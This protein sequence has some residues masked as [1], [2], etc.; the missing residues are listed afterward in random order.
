M[1]GEYIVYGLEDP[2]D[3]LYHYIGI[4]EDVYARFN[5]HITG[6]A[7]NIEK[8]AWVFECRKANAMIIMR[9]LERVTSSTEA[10]EREKFW[11]EHFTQLGHPLLNKEVYL[12]PTA[13]QKVLE[14]HTQGLSLRDIAKATGL[15]FYQVQRVCA[16]KGN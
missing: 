10:L 4:T 5:Q 8:N 13:T 14:F 6:T 12:P 7:G 1:N 3:H 9:E 15:K 2:R 11:K 16:G